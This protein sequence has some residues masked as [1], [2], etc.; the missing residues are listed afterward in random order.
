MLA[1]GVAACQ[2]PRD[3]VFVVVLIEA[4]WA[5][6]LHSKIFVG[7]QLDWGGRLY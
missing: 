7:V 1:E 5:G 6:D 2:D 3:L 4:D